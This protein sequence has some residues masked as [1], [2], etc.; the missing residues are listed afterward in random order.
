MHIHAKYP[1]KG[2]YYPHAISFG[3]KSKLIGVRKIRWVPV[4]GKLISVVAITI[5][6]IIFLEILLVI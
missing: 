2:I 4:F 5:S 1:I 6:T 3:Q